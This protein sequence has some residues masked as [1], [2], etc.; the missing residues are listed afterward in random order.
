MSENYLK[1]VSLLKIQDNFDE[2]IQEVDT[3]KDNPNNH[4]ALAT[5]ASLVAC[6]ANRENKESSYKEAINLINKAIEIIGTDVNELAMLIVYE[7]EIRTHFFFMDASEDEKNLFKLL[8]TARE[9]N[10]EKDILNFSKKLLEIN[11]NNT[12]AWIIKAS[13]TAYL[14]TSLNVITAYKEVMSYLDAAIATDSSWIR[15]IEHDREWF[16]KTLI[17]R[18]YKE[19]LEQK[20][21][22]QE[23]QKQ[24]PVSN[25]KTTVV[26]IIMALIFFALFILFLSKSTPQKNNSEIKNVVSVT[27]QKTP[28][29]IQSEKISEEQSKKNYEKQIENLEIKL[30]KA[31]PEKLESMLSSCQS[32]ILELAKSQNT[33]PFS[34]F[35]VDEYSADTYQAVVAI[36]GG[37]VSSQSERIDRFLKAQENGTKDL[38]YALNLSY[39]VMFTHDSFSGTIKDPKK[40]RCTIEPD[41]TVHAY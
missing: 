32:A 34:I 12:T 39:T 5:K 4:Y 28:E 8:N 7:T 37:S 38:R 3:L 21:E 24:S 13:S 22:F 31:T 14:A 18:G 6:L 15:I 36:D 26:P 30:K 19:G 11:A 23:F 27:P 20:V 41:L 29:Q 40:Y 33:S 16:K 2:V 9:K 35:L 10:N 17:S 25:N 1:Q